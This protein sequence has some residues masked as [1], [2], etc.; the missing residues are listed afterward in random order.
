[1]SSRREWGQDLIR[2]WNTNDWITMPQRVGGKIAPLIGA[3]E[4]K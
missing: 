3:H 1:M 2:S 4:M